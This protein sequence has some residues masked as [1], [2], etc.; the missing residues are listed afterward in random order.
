MRTATTLLALLLG[1]AGA[2]PAVAAGEPLTVTGKIA[3]AAAGISFEV[4][5]KRGSFL[6]TL[7]AVPTAPSPTADDPEP[8]TPPD[9]PIVSFTAQRI[10]ALAAGTHLH[11]LGRRVDGISDETPHIHMIE[12]IIASDSFIQP[13]LTPEQSKKGLS[14][15]EGGAGM[16]GARPQLDKYELKLARDRLIPVAAAGRR[17]A[18]AAKRIVVVE[19]ERTT[20]AKAKGP[21][22]L[23]PTRIAI[24]APQIPMG[25]YD[26]LLAPP[27]A[28]GRAGL[29][30]MRAGR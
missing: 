30:A 7:P 4:Q 13:A 12:A 6:V 11:V 3:K 2:A 29:G 14:W 24:L 27:P 28:V 26:I 18:L 22:G 25:E 15:T 21:I 8:E 23:R 1:L 10:D 19:G 16:I 5:G 20:D 17:D 9:F